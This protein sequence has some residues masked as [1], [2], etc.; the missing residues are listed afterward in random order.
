MSEIRKKI[1][2]IMKEY[3]DILFI[4][5]EKNQLSLLKNLVYQFDSKAKMIVMEAS[6][7]LDGK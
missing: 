5:V 1:E 3:K 2:T 6:E 7:M 4:V